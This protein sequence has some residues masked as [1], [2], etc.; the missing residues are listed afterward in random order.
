[1][2]PREKELLYHSNVV[3]EVASKLPDSLLQML[4]TRSDIVMMTERAAGVE[5]TAVQIVDHRLQAVQESKVVF[6]EFLKAYIEPAVRVGKEGE[7]QSLFAVIDRWVA[8]D[9]RSALLLLASGGMGKTTAALALA[10]RVAGGTGGRLYMFVSLPSLGAGAEKKGA[11]EAAV[12]RQLH[13]KEGEQA[14]EL[15][16]RQLV[17]ILDQL[18][19]PLE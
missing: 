19:H 5:L 15:R 7:P 2:F 4:G 8:S 3:F 11:I 1:M 6:G 17:F 14:D 16:R 13:V 9:A 18:P 12:L 10:G